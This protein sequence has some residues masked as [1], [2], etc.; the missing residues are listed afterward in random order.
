MDTRAVKNPAGY[1][2]EPASSGRAEQRGRSVNRVDDPDSVGRT[3]LTK[4]LAKEGAFWP[5]CG[6]RLAHESL[7]RPVSFRDWGAVDLQRCKSTRVEV[8]GRDVR[9]QI[10][11][12]ER[13]W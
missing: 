12:T 2:T 10:R 5:R 9:R 11:G 7:D 6:Q 8:S 1:P 4:F 13:E 3:E